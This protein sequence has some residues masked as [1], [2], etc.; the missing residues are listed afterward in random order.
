ME[1]EMNGAA[2]DALNATVERLAAAAEMLERA[3]EQ[4]AAGQSGMLEQIQGAREE[5]QSSVARIVAT[6]EKG[7]EFASLEERL[8]AAMAEV[9]ELRAQQGVRGTERK[10]L[11][12]AASGLL[13]KHGIAAGAE[14]DSTALDAALASLSI[15]QR[16]AVKSQLLRAGLVG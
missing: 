3:A 12:M 13:A 16:I 14:V 11:P 2:G 10:T 6:T 1:K 5:M 9:A 8:Q 7:E 15:E 4:L